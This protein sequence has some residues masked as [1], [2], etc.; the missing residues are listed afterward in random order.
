MQ[1]R[2]LSFSKANLS[3]RS[4]RKT[5]CRVFYMDTVFSEDFLEQGQHV[6]RSDFH[7]SNKGQRFMGHGLSKGVKFGII[8]LVHAK[9]RETEPLIEVFI[10]FRCFPA[11]FGG[12]F[13]SGEGY[14]EQL[15]DLFDLVGKRGG[16]KFQRGRQAEGQAFPWGM[17]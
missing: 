14:A 12:R 13:L 16:E 15:T 6:F 8:G 2:V 17:W 9:R 10:G 5:E 7:R 11:D 3:R 1:P 4:D